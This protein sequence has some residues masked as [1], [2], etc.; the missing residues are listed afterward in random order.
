M[1]KTMEGVHVGFLLKVT[2]KT[3][4]RQWDR[5]WSRAAAGSVLKEV[6]TQTLGTYIDRQ[7][8]P[9]TEWVKL[10][11]IYGVYNMDT[12]Y[13]VLGRRREPWWQQTAARKQLRATLVEIWR[14]K[15][16]SERNMEGVAR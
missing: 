11:P 8:K 2:G 7:K 5:T 14:R 6:G 3:S 16:S 10:I 1:N 9:M 13:K 4:N 12:G 15:G